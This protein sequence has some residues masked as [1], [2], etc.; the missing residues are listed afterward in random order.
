MCKVVV[1]PETKGEVI[2]VVALDVVG[3]MGIQAS[4]EVVTVEAT[5]NERAKAIGK[6]IDNFLLC[7]EAHSPLT[8]RTIS[9]SLLGLAMDNVFF[10]LGFKVA[11]KML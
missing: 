5:T 8:R 10:L 7:P 6:D 3:L 9:I 11:L 2:V 1:V 4:T